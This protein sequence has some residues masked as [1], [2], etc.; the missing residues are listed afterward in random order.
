MGETAKQKQRRWWMRALAPALAG[1]VGGLIGAFSAAY[2]SG[3]KAEQ[4]RGIVRDVETLKEK[5]DTAFEY[6]IRMDERWDRMRDY[7]QTNE[8][9]WLRVL[10]ED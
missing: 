8:E 10:G 2:A 1:V 7:M 5:A 3:E 4:Q 6:I 9:R